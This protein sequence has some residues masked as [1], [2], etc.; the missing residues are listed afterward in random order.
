M[1][2]QLGFSWMA[3]RMP[4]FDFDQL[5][6]NCY[7][8]FHRFHVWDHIQKQHETAKELYHIEKHHVCRGTDVGCWG[9]LPNPKIWWK[10]LPW[11]VQQEQWP[12]VRQRYFL[13]DA[14]GCRMLQMFQVSVVLEMWNAFVILAKQF[15]KC[16]HQKNYCKEFW[17]WAK[18]W[19]TFFWTPF[20]ATGTRPWR[21]RRPWHYIS[22]PIGVHLVVV[23][24]LNWPNGIHRTPIEVIWTEL[25]CCQV[26]SSISLDH[27][28]PDGFFFSGVLED[29][30]AKGLEVVFVSS[31]R[32]EAS[33]KEYFGEMPWLALDF[34]DRKLKVVPRGHV[35]DFFFSCK[36]ITILICR[37][38]YIYISIC[39]KLQ[40]GF[41]CH[42]L[43]FYLFQQALLGTIS[44]CG[45]ILRQEQLS[46]AFKVQGIPSLDTWP[47]GKGQW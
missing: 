40:I 25:F 39:Q 27:S 2:W 15:E 21:E 13:D 4:K 45:S 7:V 20:I 10:R 8:W 18:M 36:E 33:F 3:G 29:L 26:I 43:R 30:K 34:S 24:L 31:D 23:L 6:R 17:L 35:R 14:D 22:A 11:P 41:S 28:H 12:W 42:R 16:H 5:H 19:A 38:I 37:L 1:P 32:D 46:S 47:R 44:T 9:F